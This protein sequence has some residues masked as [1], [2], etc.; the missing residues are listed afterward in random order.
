MKK[1][2]ALRRIVLYIFILRIF[3]SSS[4]HLEKL[5][6][7]P[8]GEVNTLDGRLVN[9]P[10]ASLASRLID[11]TAG[12][13][14]FGVKDLLHDILLAT[15]SGNKGDAH[16]VGDDG[17]GQCDAARGRLGRVFDGS[18][19]GAGLAQES[20]AGKERACVS[21]GAAAEKQEVEDGETDRVAAG[22]AGDEG[23]LIL[24]GELLEIVKVGGID[25]VDGGLLVLGNLVKK[26]RLEEGVVGVVVI[27]RHGTL[28]GKEDLPLG[29]LDLVVGAGRGG[30]KSLS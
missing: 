17:Q 6:K 3:S 25:G 22:E 13:T 29:E 10:A 18:D 4:L 11:K 20:V 15:T 19:P 26:F 2:D 9:E 28:I 1:G 27:E 5:E 7:G 8:A 23:L 30:E 14:V 21:V 16:G 24:V 12:Q